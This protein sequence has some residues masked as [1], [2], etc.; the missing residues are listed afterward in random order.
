MDTTH[1]ES[2]VEKA[3]AYQQKGDLANAEIFFSEALSND[4]NSVEALS[5]LGM[6]YLMKGN[7]QQA[8]DS[9][10]KALSLDP[11][12]LESLSNLGFICTQ[13][14]DFQNAL[15]YLEKAQKVAPKRDDIGLQI[16]QIKS[17]FGQYDEAK[18]ILKPFLNSEPLSQNSYLMMAQLELL[19]NNSVA[20]KSTL[21]HL[22]KK[23]PNLVEAM[24]NLASILETEGKAEDA[25]NYLTQAAQKAPFHFQAN[26]ELGRFLGQN[27][28]A[29]EGLTYLKKAVQ[30]EPGDWGIHV[31]L[32]NTY[33]EIGDFDNTVKSYKKALSINPND[34]GTRQNLSRVMS[35]FVPPWHLKMLADHERNDAFEQ[36]IEKA[37]KAESVALDIGTGSGLLAMMAAKHGAQ[38]VYACEQSKYI[39]EAAKEN[40][41]KNGLTEKVQLFQ[42]KSTQLTA[43]DLNPKPNIIVAEIF[44]SGLLGEHAVPSFRHALES[45]CEEGTKVIPKA[46]EVKGKLLHAPK[47]SSVNPITKISGFDLSGFDQFRVPEEYITQNLSEV[48]HEFCSD[49]F[50]ILDVDFENLWPAMAPNQCRRLDVSVEINSSDP[51]HGIAFWFTLFMDDSITLSSAPGRKDNHWGQAVSFF[52]Q[53]IIGSSGQKLKVTVNYTDTKIWFEDP[54]LV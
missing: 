33:Q 10:Q 23:A 15:V 42:A 53:P 16:A 21:E 11:E 14:Q 22:L 38:K 37:I 39:A 32:G 36:A 28:Q 27:G 20:A 54:Q 30:I 9:W 6:L 4:P 17:H 13:I 12:N 5:N 46:A 52:N 41:G 34:L 7:A 48:T 49:E 44:D 26:L 8:I 1:K 35:R 24:I 50:K 25:H 3:K 18:G 2:L 51:I 45:L 43:E 47:S 31:H 29:E 19:T 40:I